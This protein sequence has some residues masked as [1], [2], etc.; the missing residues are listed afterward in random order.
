MPQLAVALVVF[1]VPSVLFYRLIL[2]HFYVRGSF[3]YDTGL[4]AAVMWHN[5]PALPVPESLDGLSFFNFHVAPVLLLVSALSEVV[6]ATMAQT[7]AGFVGLSH[8]LLAL[9]MF[10]LLVEGFGKRR[11]WPLLV[12]ALAAIA[13]ACNGLAIA[14]ARYP[15][16]ETFG[17]ACLLLFFV[18]LVLRHR[19]PAVIAF[20]LALATREDFGLHAF[21]FLFV[22]IA[23]NRWRGLPWRIDR[24]LL[25]FAVAGLAWSAA[26]LVWQ[27]HA[28]P[29]SASFFRVY[30]GEPPFAHVGSGLVW[31]RVRGWLLLHGGIL[32]AALFALFW[33]LRSRNPLIFAGFL[34]CVPWALLQF[35]AV[36]DLAGWMVGYYAFPFL[37]AMAWPWLGV[38]AW[39]DGAARPLSPSLALLAMTAL[40]LLP[41]QVLQLGRDYDPG[42]IT[43]PEAF[44][45]S[46]S[47]AQQR[48]TDRAVAAIAA[49]RPA[50][51]RLVVDNSVAALLPRAFARDEIAGW[52][53]G[54][55]DTVAYFADGFD[56][57]NLRAINLP[58]HYA[59]PGT[60]LRIATDRP[61]ETVRQLPIPLQATR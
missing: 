41:N 11:G 39:P 60:E 43:L 58:A 44:L 22:W 30:L 34:A 32:L 35:F 18:A 12:A 36:S 21:G 46:P 13:F 57:E 51:G 16:F 40:S 5:A 25:G 55:P 61:A 48:A 15:H 9:A 10:W 31:A 8:G 6:P 2:F 42:R 26:A 54:P 56:A 1:A 38:L 29:G 45:R 27:H 28:F 37:I 4:L 24:P 7:F 52:Q 14:I 33:A 23:L 47:R 59:V 53:D 20:V 19:V 17:A 3:L 50:L 49:A